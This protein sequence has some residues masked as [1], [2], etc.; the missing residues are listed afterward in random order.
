[1]NNNFDRWSKEFIS[2]DVS[3]D[4]WKKMG[5]LT[6]K[7]GHRWGYL[8]RHIKSLKRNTILKYAGLGWATRRKVSIHDKKN[9]VTY[10]VKETK[11]L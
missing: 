9:G 1:M 6:Q 4:V 7:Y 2:F 11:Y 5:F 8:F 10:G 3:S